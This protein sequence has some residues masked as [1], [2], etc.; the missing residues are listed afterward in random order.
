MDYKILEVRIEYK[1]GKLYWI[2]VLVEISKGDVRAIYASTL[3]KYGFMYIKP[4]DQLN[5]KLLQEIAAT[6]IETEERDTIF[7]NWKR[8]YYSKVK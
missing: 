6:G 2:T 7:P 4:T 5:E 8:N 1:A 3:T